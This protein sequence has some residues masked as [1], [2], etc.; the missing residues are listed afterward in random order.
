MV[1]QTTLLSPSRSVELNSAAVIPLRIHNSIFWI[2]AHADDADPNVNYTPTQIY[3]HIYALSHRC[4][5]R[6]QPKQTLDY[7]SHYGSRE[8]HQSMT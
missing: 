6:G 8:S 4:K 2:I 5:N 3:I 7:T 1:W